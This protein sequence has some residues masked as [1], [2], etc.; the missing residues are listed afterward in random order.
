MLTANGWREFPE[1]SGD[2]RSQ[3]ILV[4]DPGL[5]EDCDTI[6]TVQ[7]D[8]RAVDET[9]GQHVRLIVLVLWYT[10]VQQMGQRY[11]RSVYL[12][13]EG[14]S[15]NLRGSMCTYD[16]RPVTPPPITRIWGDLLDGCLRGCPRGVMSLPNVR[17]ILTIL[18]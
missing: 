3:T 6:A 12:P 2:L 18:L 4:T 15:Q 9:Y 14:M 1:G 8:P 17:G 5:A 7:E 11:T 16:T 13:A 10:I